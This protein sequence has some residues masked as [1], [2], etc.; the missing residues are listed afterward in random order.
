MMVFC[1]VSFVVL[2]SSLLFLLFFFGAVEVDMDL[3]PAIINLSTWVSAY[4]AVFLVS[5]E[6]RERVCLLLLQALSGVF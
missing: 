6:S 4:V 5:I 2:D 3:F 1:L